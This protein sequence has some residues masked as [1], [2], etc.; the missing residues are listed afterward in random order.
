MSRAAIKCYTYVVIR[1]FSDFCVQETK[2]TNEQ[3]PSMQALRCALSVCEFG[4][5]MVSSK[6]YLIDASHDPE[7]DSVPSRT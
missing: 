4:V 3:F 7:V 5:T 2:A 1:N 6:A